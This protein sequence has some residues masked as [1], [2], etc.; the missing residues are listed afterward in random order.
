MPEVEDNNKDCGS[1][2]DST[3][4]VEP[5]S[6]GPLAKQATSLGYAARLLKHADE[7][8]DARRRVQ[9][10]TQALRED[11]NAATRQEANAALAAYAKAEHRLARSRWRMQQ[12]IEQ[13]TGRREPWFRDREEGSKS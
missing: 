8:E 6:Y 2:G 4:P 7:F 9:A 11:A 3:S 1:R 5:Y 13:A 10:A 12:A